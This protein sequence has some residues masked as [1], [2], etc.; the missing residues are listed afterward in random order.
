[1][2]VVDP[3]PFMMQ[4]LNGTDERRLHANMTLINIKHSSGGSPLQLTFIDGT[5]ITA[6]ALIADGGLLSPVRGHVL[7]PQDP[8]TH[9]VVSIASMFMTQRQLTP[10]C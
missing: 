8:A 9:P 7:G 5:H 10:T 2:A 4:M 3:A 6:D 1:M